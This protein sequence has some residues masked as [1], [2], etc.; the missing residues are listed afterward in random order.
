MLPNALVIPVVVIV[1]ALKPNA[2]VEFGHSVTA[3]TRRWG[4]L[5]FAA[6]MLNLYALAD[7]EA[8]PA[9]LAFVTVPAERGIQ[10]ARASFSK[11]GC[12]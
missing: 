10:G 3:C 1:L 9:T 5:G 4:R 2:Y 7:N 6:S 8:P 11:L 12:R